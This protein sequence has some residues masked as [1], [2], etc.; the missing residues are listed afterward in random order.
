MH[1]LFALTN[2]FPTWGLVLG[3]IGA[4]AVIVIAGTLLSILGDKLADTSGLSA[5]WIGLILLAGITS[6]PEVVASSTATLTNA[7]NLGFGNVV[8]SNFFNVLIIAML[9]FL[10]GPGP[11]M[12]S[13][14]AT[15]IIP[16]MQGI[17][18][19]AL[20]GVGIF[21]VQMTN[22]SFVGRLFSITLLIAWI[23]GVMMSFIAERDAES[24]EEV[25]NKKDRKELIKVI[26]K[27]SLTALFVA[28]GGILLIAFTEP[29]SARE[30][31]IGPF[32]VILGQS[33]V[34]TMIVAVATSTPEIVVSI[35]AFRIGR[36]NMAVANIFGSCTFNMCII[37]IMEIFSPQKS[38]FVG[39]STDHITTIFFAI[40][41]TTVAA[42]GLVFRSR[43]SFLFLGFDALA[44]MLL[45]IVGC[46]IFFLQS[47]TVN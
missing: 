16:M 17:F 21:T 6:I 38:I 32:K 42:I 26:A 31:A 3:T 34:G 28:F 11:V 13:V 23:L 20:A 24:E 30:L 2:N 4:T 7:S 41:I 36:V 35:S 27:F 40:M 45:Y 19:M 39:L 33:F 15:Q 43:K 10:Q 47:V 44:I 37:P 5:S 9:D 22:S 12:L 25:T 18:L 1:L 29:L 46:Y 8:G 14:R